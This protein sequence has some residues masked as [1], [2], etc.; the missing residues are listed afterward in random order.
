MTVWLNVVGIE[1]EVVE[2]RELEDDVSQR[3][4]G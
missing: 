1:S 3:L 2:V 4:D